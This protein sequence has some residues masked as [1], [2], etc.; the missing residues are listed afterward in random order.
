M[1]ILVAPN[2][3][4]G[5]TSAVEVARVW[6][7]GLAARGFAVDVC[8]MADGGD[9][10]LDVVRLA[11]GGRCHATGVT[12]PLGAKLRAEWLEL[13][14][15]TALVESAA[16]G[17]RTLPEGRVGGLAATSRGVGELI[18]A[19]AGTCRR[20]AVGVGG[21]A[22]TDGGAGA[23]EAL[24]VPPGGLWAGAG[25]VELELLCDVANPLRGP[26]GAAAVY[27]P[28]KGLGPAEV[29]AAER[30]LEEFA[31]AWPQ[32]I[33][34]AAVAGT[35]AG[36][37]L[38]F[39]LAAGCGAA[40]REGAVYV[41]DAVGLD[42]RIAAADL[43]VTGEGRFDRTSMMGKAPGEVI[44]RARAAGRRVV[45]VAG[46][47]TGDPDADIVLRTLGARR[48]PDAVVDIVEVA[49]SDDPDAGQPT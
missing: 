36:G 44:R 40:L 31:R 29:A 26:Q 37:G 5:T 22:S 3:F 45:V 13:D 42:R 28:Q 7:E 25:D 20:I 49:L 43:V 21:T 23:L 9:G 14:D 47:A 24:G 4:K 8:P 39:G 35:G 12:G 15:G 16:C 34:L 2:S 18:A 33:D 17:M 41:A 38:A 46:S 48:F 1:R 11:R 27:G 30:R 32:G 19:A 6:G 10:T